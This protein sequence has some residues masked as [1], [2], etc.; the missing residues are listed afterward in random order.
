M[1]HAS[2]KP[3]FEF[4]PSVRLRIVEQNYEREFLVQLRL[5]EHIIAL[6]LHRHRLSAASAEDFTSHVKLKLIEDDYA[7]LRKFEGRSSLRTYLTTVVSHL[8]LD[9]L[10]SAWGKWRPSVEAVRGGS[11]LMD[12]E[13][14]LVRDNYSFEEACEILATNH[15]VSLPRAELEQLA[16]RLTVR[17]RRRVESDAVL[18]NLPSTDR[19]ADDALIERELQQH[20]HHVRMALKRVLAK[21]PAQDRELLSLTFHDGRTIADAARLLRLHQKPLYRRV[22]GL[23]RRLRTALE[24][25]GIN[26]S[27]ALQFS[28]GD[29]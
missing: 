5:I 9:F 13:K 2:S 16:A 19:P 3:A 29:R 21:L 24:A 12:L 27:A 17:F 11:I 8:F 6:V 7:I 4:G 25:E 23:L 15:G 1:V 18:V 14:L 20:A 26:A 28:A 10:N 22:D